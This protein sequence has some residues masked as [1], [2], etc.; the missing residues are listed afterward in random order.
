MKRNALNEVVKAQ[1]RNVISEA[2]LV[3]P[4]VDKAVE[5]LLVRRSELEA[6]IKTAS[7]HFDSWKII[8]L[9]REQIARINEVLQDES[10]DPATRRRHGQ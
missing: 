6:E 8:K 3:Q 2:Q 5:S 1:L 4:N 9:C 7:Q 10:I